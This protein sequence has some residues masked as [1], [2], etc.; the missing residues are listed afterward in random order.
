MVAPSVALTQRRMI[1]SGTLGVS[2]SAQVIDG[3]IIGDSGSRN[4]ADSS[5]GVSS[6]WSSL[7]ALSDTAP[8]PGP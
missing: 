2:Q 1:L 3:V 8:Q 6:S 4:V 5:Q 7:A